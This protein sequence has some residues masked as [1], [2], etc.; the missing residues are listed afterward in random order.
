MH[1]EKKPDPIDLEDEIEEDKVVGNTSKNEREE[2]IN[3]KV[4]V[5]PIVE[6]IKQ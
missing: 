5:E 3:S 4:V 6:T 1:K 2:N